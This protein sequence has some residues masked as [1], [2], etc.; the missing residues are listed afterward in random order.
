ME[1]LGEQVYRI[2]KPIIDR[3]VHLF[4]FAEEQWAY[5]LHRNVMWT[6]DYEYVSTLPTYD[7]RI[8]FWLDKI[9]GMDRV[10]F[11]SALKHLQTTYIYNRFWRL[12]P[13][14]FT[15]EESELFFLLGTVLDN[16]DIPSHLPGLCKCVSDFFTA[17]DS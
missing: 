15:R 10:G 12:P 16:S 14:I 4:S 7:L 17:L 8:F 1:S 13:Y 11:I 9:N 3:Y 5:K 2:C 6:S